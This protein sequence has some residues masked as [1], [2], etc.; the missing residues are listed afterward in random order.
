M[1]GRLD[2]KV[3]LVTGAGSGIG[4][5]TALA[6]A[7]EGAKVV[8]SGRSLD[9]CHETVASIRG[10]GG[11][12]TFVRADVSIASDVVA[13]IQTTVDT[14]GRLDCAHNNAGVGGAGF[15][16]HEYPE[17][18][19]DQNIAINLKGVWLC[20]KYEITHML[21]QGGGAIVNTSSGAGLVG[22][23]MAIGYSASKHGVIGLTK[24]AALAYAHSGIRVN[25]VCPGYV[26]TPMLEVILAERPEAEQAWLANQPI[27]RLG[28]PEE[29]AA[30]V[31]WL[32]S[33][34]ASFV[35]GA[36]LPVD[37]GYT[38]R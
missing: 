17:E 6:F 5:A 29:I 25:A 27:G 16:P 2:G 4:R 15:L 22:V 7:D 24:S 8:V 3:A 37:G 18:L 31:V 26:R 30:L 38:A 35:T 36:A 19:W 12:A 21:R 32:C 34:A 11:E 23:P 20:L 28:S 13:L 14:Y 10:A 1:P 33:D 9:G